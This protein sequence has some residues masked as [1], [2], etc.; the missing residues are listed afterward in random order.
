MSVY[1]LLI[2]TILLLFL[3]RPFA[4]QTPPRNHQLRRQQQYSR[5]RSCKSLSRPQ[6][7]SLC[8]RLQRI[9]NRQPFPTPQ[10]D[11]LDGIDPTHGEEKRLVPSGTNPL[12][13]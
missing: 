1:T 11:K 13:N 8:F 6:Q 2:F 4:A 7:R 3:L 5:F 12:H 10:A 9:H